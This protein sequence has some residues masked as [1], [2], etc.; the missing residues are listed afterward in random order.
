MKKGFTLIE[1]LVVLGLFAIL[2]LS[3]TNFLIQMVQNSN[4]VTTE[5]EVRQNANKIMQ[6]IGTSIRT[7]GCVNWQT[8]AK[9]YPD[10]ADGQVDMTIWT[11]SD[12][13]NTLVDEFKVFFTDPRDYHDLP[14]DNHRGNQGK[15]YR[16][17][18][19]I[20]SEWGVAA[21]SCANG[22]QCG[23]NCV[24]GLSVS[25]SAGTNKAVTVNLTVQATTSATNSDFCGV[26]SISDSFVPRGQY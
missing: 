8:G 19:Q 10:L 21:L 16:N 24:N 2:T 23:T 3:A 22:G 26:T 17:G 14:S 15:V 6:E 1:L 7:A 4:R 13:C 25:G 9:N 20:S 18:R 12:N 11:Y 5:N